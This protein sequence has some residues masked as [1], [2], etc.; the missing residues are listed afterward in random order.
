MQCWANTNADAQPKPRARVHTTNCS[1]RTSLFL[2]D[3]LRSGGVGLSYSYVE[4]V[5]LNAFQFAA[6]LSQQLR[7]LSQDVASRRRV[8]TQR[9]HENFVASDDNPALRATFCARAYRDFE[10]LYDVSVVAVTQDD[11]RRALVARLSLSG[12]AWDNAT[13]FARRFVTA[14]GRA[15]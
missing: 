2:A 9:C 7:P 10:G 14:I 15:P 6:F 4:S 3:D 8:T 13:A 1:T 12:V 5:S 11:D